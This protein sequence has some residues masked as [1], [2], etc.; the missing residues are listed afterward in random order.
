MTLR[1]RYFL[2][3][4]VA[5]I[6]AAGLIGWHDATMPSDGSSRR[7]GAQVVPTPLATNGGRSLGLAMPYQALRAAAPEP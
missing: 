5:L 4:F 3:G 6:V 7:I 2:I 1:A